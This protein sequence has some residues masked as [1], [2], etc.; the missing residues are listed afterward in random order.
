MPLSTARFSQNDRLRKASENAPPL[1]PGE[2][3]EGVAIVQLALIDL[4]FRMPN[5]TAGG[6]ALPDGIFGPETQSTVI[7]FQR[8][9]GLAPDGIVGRLTLT[10][11]ERAII[12]I[13]AAQAAADSANSRGRANQHASASAHRLSQP[14]GARS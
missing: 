14:A 5:S 1:K 13:T 11:L 10:A 2:R 9:N 3:G 12:A 7:A 8:A 6:A 4:G